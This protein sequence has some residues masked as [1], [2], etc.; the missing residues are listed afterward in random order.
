M[1]TT[2]TEVIQ[3]FIEAFNAAD[4]EGALSL[5][6]PD[7][8]DHAGVPGQGPGREG[9]RTKWDVI[10]TAFPDLEWVIQQSV[11]DGDTVA[12]RYIMRGTHKGDFMGIPA[13]GNRGETTAIDMVT[14]R[15]GL[16]VEHWGVIDMMTLMVQLGVMPAPA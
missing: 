1:V 8:V 9:W 5:V 11:E 14:V 4:I 12:S 7:A 3:R 16:I 2:P 6:A 10:H 13:T 15:D